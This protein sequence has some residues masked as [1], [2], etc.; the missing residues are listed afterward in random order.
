[1]PRIPEPYVIY[2]RADSKTL[3]FT[4]NFAYGLDE[5]VCA[6]W[7]RR[8]FLALP[9]ELSNF[10]YPKTKATA[11]AGGDALRTCLASQKSGRFGIKK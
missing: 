5:R 7:R 11:N 1:M 6:Q 8:S 10:R 4:L 2:E 3:R 9:D